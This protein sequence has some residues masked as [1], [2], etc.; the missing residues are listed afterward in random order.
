MRTLQ[1]RGARLPPAHHRAAA[2]RG[3]RRGGAR[4]HRDPAHRQRPELVVADA[5]LDAAPGPGG[6][7]PGDADTLII[8][9]RGSAMPRLQF[10]EETDLGPDERALIAS[11]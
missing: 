3:L 9:W 5:G 10:I 1:A 8:Y 6:A 4:L 7:A 2:A 11:A